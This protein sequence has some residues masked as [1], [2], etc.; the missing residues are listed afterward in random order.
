MNFTHNISWFIQT[1]AVTLNKGYLVLL[2][3]PNASE[4][5]KL[6]KRSP[7]VQLGNNRLL[8]SRDKITAHLDT[9]QVTKGFTHNT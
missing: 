6:S 8:W 9:T 3:L 1:K 2:I 7:K 4:C 5:R